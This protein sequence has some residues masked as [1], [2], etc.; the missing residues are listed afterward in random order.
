MHTLEEIKAQ[1]DKTQAKIAA[2]LKRKAKALKA[3]GKAGM[4]NHILWEQF[5]WLCQHSDI[6]HLLDT[7]DC[8]ETQNVQAEECGDSIEVKFEGEDG[9]DL[10]YDFSKKDNRVLE[11]KDGDVM[12]INDNGSELRMQFFIKSPIM[13]IPDI[14]TWDLFTRLCKTA[15]I[16]NKLNANANS[17]DNDDAYVPAKQPLR[18]KVKGDAAVRVEWDSFLS[19]GDIYHNDISQADNK[20]IKHTNGTLTVAAR[21]TENNKEKVKLAFFIKTKI[22]V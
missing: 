11:I 3:A 10:I 5:V 20:R 18:V 2:N 17:Y 8:P 13:A 7:E 14:V 22:R 1:Y 19:T 12:V 4:A 16:V 15:D 21:D 9:F 6:V